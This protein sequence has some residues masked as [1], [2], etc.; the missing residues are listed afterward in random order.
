MRQVNKLSKLCGRV[1]GIVF[2]LL[3][4][5]NSFGQ[6]VN[7]GNGSYTTQFPGVDEA[8]RNTYPSGTP[9]TTGIAATQPAPTNDWWSAKIKNPHAGNLFNYPYTLKTVNSG[10]VVTYIP[11][12]VIDDILPVTVGVSGLNA[13]AANVSDFSDWT[14]TMD[15]S[16]AEHNFRATAGIG[17]PFLYFTKA[18]TDLAQLTVASGSVTITN[19]MLVITDARNGADFAVYAPSG[20]SWTKD[21]N[22]Y[23]SD[24]NGQTHWR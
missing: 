16:N 1:L 2:F 14:V 18:D 17:M 5:M 23:T 10:L 21:G 7:V 15:W 6:I 9:Y 11:W 13:S 8:G 3:I 20:S 4:F 24:L 19:E 22:I 12:G